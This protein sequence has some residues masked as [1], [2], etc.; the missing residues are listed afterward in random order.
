MWRVNFSRSIR[1]S[2]GLGDSIAEPPKLGPPAV[3]ADPDSRAEI[4]GAALDHAPGVD[5][6][7]RLLGQRSRAAG[8][9]AEQGSLAAVALSR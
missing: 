5:A 7:L 6:V 1:G 3:A 8:G 4:D 9:G 2:P